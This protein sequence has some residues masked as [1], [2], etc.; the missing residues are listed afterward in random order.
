M[1]NEMQAYEQSTL[2]MKKSHKGNV[3]RVE[4]LDSSIL[5]KITKQ[6]DDF[7]EFEV[8]TNQK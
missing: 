8:N 2:D 6:N 3:D 1:E 5:S 7:I 4:R